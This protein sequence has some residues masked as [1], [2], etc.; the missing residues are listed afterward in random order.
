MSLPEQHQEPLQHLLRMGVFLQHLL[1]NV[2]MTKEEQP[3]Q[4][5][6]GGMSLALFFREETEE[7]LQDLERKT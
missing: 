1:A 2:R 3:L 5:H 4:N 7:K 6:M